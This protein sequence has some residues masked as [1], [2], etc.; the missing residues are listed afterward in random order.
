MDAP[1]MFDGPREPGGQLMLT[2]VLSGLGALVRGKAM[3]GPSALP[4]GLLGAYPSQG[5]FGQDDFQ[6]VMR[7]L[8]L[9]RASR[10]DQGLQAQLQHIPE[11]DP[12]PAP[13]DRSGS[14]HR[15]PADAPVVGGPCLRMTPKGSAPGM[16]G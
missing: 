7:E 2:N 4:G 16:G 12:T 14:G 15:G 13:S 10:P 5:A 3:M 1:L 11:R 8:W 9:N 6:Q